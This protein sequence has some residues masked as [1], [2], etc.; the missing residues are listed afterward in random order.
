MRWNIPMET[1]GAGAP[2]LLRLNIINTIQLHGNIFR[3]RLHFQSYLTSS[4][5]KYSSSMPPKYVLN[6]SRSATTAFYT[7]VFVEKMTVKRHTLSLTIIL[8]RSQ[9]K[10]KYCCRVSQR[11]AF[12]Y[13][14]RLYINSDN[15]KAQNKSITSIFFTIRCFCV[16][17]WLCHTPASI[18]I[19]LLPS[20]LRNRLYFTIR[21]ISAFCEWRD[22]RIEFCQYQLN[23]IDRIGRLFFEQVLRQW[24][25]SIFQ[26]AVCESSIA[27]QSTELFGRACVKNIDLKAR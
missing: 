27:G 22:R 18:L 6:V 11:L 9:R 16:F 21:I 13:Y 7:C 24:L 23:L 26:F 20:E 3:N 25:G 14:I 1:L 12:I 2:D 10:N 5:A 17:A 4:R 8:S 19:L 15:I